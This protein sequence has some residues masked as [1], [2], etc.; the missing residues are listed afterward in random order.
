[1]T[2]MLRYSVL[3][4]ASVALTSV[5]AG[6]SAFAGTLYAQYYPPPPPGYGSPPAVPS[7]YART[8]SGRGTGSRR[9][10]T[11]RGDFGQCRARRRNRSR[12]RRSSRCGTPRFGPQR[13]RML[14][15]FRRN[16][17][18]SEKISRGFSVGGV[19]C[20]MGAASRCTA[21]TGGNA[22]ARSG[23]LG[24]DS[25]AHTARHV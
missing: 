6:E 7:R 21:T 13:G 1:M 8:L 5:P 18:S 14:L 2:Q 19:S 11:D 24:S 4:L 10:C 22:C 12:L 3:F 23:A 16:R 25:L 15:R 9:R 17:G 20:C